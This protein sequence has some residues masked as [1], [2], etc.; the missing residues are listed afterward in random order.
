M[1]NRSSTGALIGDNANWNQQSTQI[2]S[3]QHKSSQVNTNQVKSNERKKSV[4]FP[5]PWQAIG[6]SLV[7]KKVIFFN[8]FLFAL[9][10]FPTDLPVEHYFPRHLH[11]GAKKIV[12]IIWS[13]AEDTTSIQCC[14]FS[15]L[16]LDNWHRRKLE[17]SVSPKWN[18][19][20]TYFGKMENLVRLIKILEMNV[21][22]KA[23]LFYSWPKIWEFLPTKNLV[24]EPQL[25]YA[26]DV[27]CNWHSIISV[28][29]SPSVN[30]SPLMQP[31]SCS[32][33]SDIKN[34]LL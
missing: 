30:I 12:Q 26:S 24:V 1:S 10:L 3:S 20:W 32:C 18:V 2:K 28:K 15:H 8:I 34:L 16:A 27:S 13:K 5:R 17:L 11:T 6:G 9:I 14:T 33:P 29:L 4:C 21:L 31:A 19:K 22:E 7:W 23:V 25:L